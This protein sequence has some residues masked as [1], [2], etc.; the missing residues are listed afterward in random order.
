MNVLKSSELKD[1]GRCIIRR[2]IDM[3]INSLKENAYKTS[4][5]VNKIIRN[6]HESQDLTSLKTKILDELNNSEQNFDFS[7]EIEK[8][9]F[10][11]EMYNVLYRYLSEDTR[12]GNK[13]N[14]E[15][16]PAEKTVN[17]F[18]IDVSVT[19]NAIFFTKNGCEVVKYKYSKPNITMKGNVQDQSATTSLE[20]YAMLRYGRMVCD[21]MNLSGDV[22]ISAN[23]YFLKK[24]K[25]DAKKG[26]YQ[27]KYFTNTGKSVIGLSETVYDFGNTNI[28]SENYDKQFVPQFEE[29]IRGMSCAGTDKCD[30][31]ELKGVCSFKSLPAKLDLS[32][33]KK[34]S[35]KDIK[36]NNVQK[37]A[38]AFE[39]GVAR[40]NAGAGSGKTLITALRAATL[41]NKGVNPKNILMITFTEAGAKEMKERVAAY[42]KEYDV[43]CNT[44]DLTVVT[45][46]AFAYNIVKEEYS[47]L[48][49]NS[50][51]TIIDDIEQSMIIADI[52]N[53]HPII[54]GLDYVNFDVMMYKAAGAVGVVKDIF[55]IIKQ[56]DYD[57]YDIP[58]IIEKCKYKVTED[59]V[60]AVFPLYQVYEQ[61]C[62]SESLITFDDQERL[63][64]EI[65]KEI[66][67]YLNRFEY[68]HIFVD[69]FQDSSALQMKLIKMLV[70]N[71]SFK[72]LMVVGDDSQAIF[73]FRNTSPKNI[74]T[75]F[76]EIN[77][78]EEDFQI[79][80][81]NNDDMW[82]FYLLE[83]YRS[84]PNIIELANKINRINQNRIDKDLISKLKNEGIEPQ[85][86]DFINKYDEQQYIVDT[87]EKLINSGKKPDDI[88]FIAATRTELSNIQHLLTAKGIDSIL[89]SPEY[90]LEN[91]N[92]K[93]LI[94]LSE[95]FEDSSVNS[96]YFAYLNILTGNK[97]FAMTSDEITKK[98]K[99]LQDT[100]DVINELD[101]DAEK[102]S[103]FKTLALA[104]G[105]GDELYEEFL[106]KV[107][108]KKSFEYILKYLKAYKKYGK[109][110]TY[111]KKESYTGVVTLTTAHSSKGLEWPIVINS[112]TGFHKEKFINDE[113]EEEKRRLFFV[114]ITRAQEQLIVT[115]LRTAY[116]KTIINGKDKEK[117]SIPNIFLENAINA[118]N[119]HNVNVAKVS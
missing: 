17:C 10:A 68:K 115:G 109:Y 41:I 66:P 8:S 73:S 37:Q 28:S 24:I 94:N 112:I 22:E 58:D 69:E 20:L 12:L 35:I 46:N 31:C 9:E 84:T 11:S 51:P 50:V 119:K 13:Y 83:N 26:E 25:D 54:D 82:D 116:T 102:I 5:L 19:P 3:D 1:A 99:K 64:F 29:F 14:C 86:I 39:N 78:P 27:P 32:Q 57:F 88:C 56:Y 62:F 100:I 16:Y 40:I 75:F 70:A 67:N 52:L 111:R 91:N 61:K 98:I 30:Y 65:F 107:F 71:K 34:K 114:S 7:T 38:I 6:Y 87:I 93:A 47:L 89:L 77:R 18:G 44:D 117:V 80:F 105:E 33:I 43:C 55:N 104:I 97:F 53:S 108:R 103:L 81:I 63:M 96:L 79:R 118:I 42:L 95:A 23:Y 59:I 45:F 113:D 36:L 76:D 4:L 2:N 90:T 74:I 60:T 15:L 85:V 48:G 101:N 21:E 106:K 110:Q 92:V 72:S 49:Y